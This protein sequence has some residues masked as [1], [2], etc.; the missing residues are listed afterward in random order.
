MAI[1]ACAQG[2]VLHEG[3]LLV[4]KFDG[5]HAGGCGV[6]YRTPGG[7]IELGEMSRDTIVRE[8]HE[9]LGA[10]VRVLDYLGCLENIWTVSSGAV[11]HQLVQ[12]Y[13]VEFV[14]ES[15]YQQEQLLITEEDEQSYG[16]WVPVDDFL[17]G[18]KILYPSGAPEL[19]AKLVR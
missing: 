1:R 13:A 8:F 15:L 17:S 10:Q 5:E 6:Y 19:L 2:M 7:G 9:E 12:M 16:Y 11:G 14:D 3:R 4:E 18:E